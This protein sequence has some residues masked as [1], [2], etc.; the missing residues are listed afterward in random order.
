MEIVLFVEGG[1][2]WPHRCV[3]HFLVE[4]SLQTLSKCV[5]SSEFLNEIINFGRKTVQSDSFRTQVFQRLL[6]DSLEGGQSVQLEVTQR[7]VSDMLE[8]VFA[9]EATKAR[10]VESAARVKPAP[11]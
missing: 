1:E 10:V 9:T 3:Q 2:L 8:R 6:E 5:R 4:L 11:P 7:R